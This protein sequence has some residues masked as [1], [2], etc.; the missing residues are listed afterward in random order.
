[1]NIR[2]FLLAL[3][4]FVAGM[5]ETLTVG[6]LPQL[7]A[8]L[9]VPT[10]LAGQL[11]SI[12][13]LSYGLAI[14]PLVALTGRRERRSLLISAMLVFAL[15]NGLVLM[16]ADY[17]LLLA[18]RV[19]MAA[20][21]A[22]IAFLCISL[23]GRLV[24][25]AQRGR[26][27]GVVFMGISG[28]IVLGIP[29][30]IWLAEGW[31]W[32]APFLVLAPMA[33]LAAGAL[34]LCLPRLAPEAGPG[35]NAWRQALFCLPQLAAQGV[36]VLLIGGHFVLFTYLAPYVHQR[37]G[38]DPAVQSWLFVLFGIGGV[39]GG[40]LGGWLSDRL[41]HARALLGVP[42]CF[43]LLMAVLPVVEGGFGAFIVPM[44]AWAAFS[45]SISPVVQNHLAH[46]YPEQ[47]AVVMALNVSAMHLGVA[48]GAMA[49]GLVVAA[50]QLRYAPWWGAALV[51]LAWLCACYA[52]SGVSRA[53]HAVSRPG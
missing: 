52:L 25:P 22:L 30:G 34:H 33:L 13:S 7:A 43:A 6:I 50:G 11:T 16:A 51:G 19:L 53:V 44:M 35:W 40:Y 48:L 17:L 26:A 37:F 49:G 39:S 31:G 8:G 1:M 4:S 36:S 12:F 3:A 28:S 23:A 42:L 14:L 24:E 38:L 21:C 20:C 32:K 10:E 29:F 27:I 15:A 5:A 41:G 46:T 9:R 47:A 18:L 45:W 2:V